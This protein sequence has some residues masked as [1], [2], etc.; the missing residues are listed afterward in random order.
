MEKQHAARVRKAF[1]DRMREIRRKKGIAQERLAL[2]S[3]LNRGY[4]GRVERGE[5]N[6][7]LVN[8]CRI[9]NAL[10]EPP[11]TLLEWTEDGAGQHPETKS[12]GEG[13]RSPAAARRHVGPNERNHAGR[14]E[15]HAPRRF[16]G[17]R[18]PGP[19]PAWR[20]RAG[21][22]RTAGRAEC[23]A[24]RSDARILSMAPA[25][26]LSRCVT[27]GTAGRWSSRPRSRSR[28]SRPT[29]QPPGIGWAGM[30]TNVYTG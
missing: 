22:Q 30:L 3:G 20:E 18:A 13:R 4:V 19:Q 25:E 16:R 15:Q 9:A 5:Q 26:W 29:R 6:I 27:P 11:S 14:D 28:C 17:G 12:A 21:G 23:E 10:R 24:G 8:I 2:E 1:G 7:S